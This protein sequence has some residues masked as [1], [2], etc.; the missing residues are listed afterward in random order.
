MV[1]RTKRHRPTAWSAGYGLITVG[2]IF[3][4]IGIAV[5]DGF[6]GGLVVGAGVAITLLGVVRLAATAGWLRSRNGE[7]GDWWLPSRDDE[8]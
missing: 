2:I 5:L 1:E 7:R 4:T 8:R 3:N 6:A